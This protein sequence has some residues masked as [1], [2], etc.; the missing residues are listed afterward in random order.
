MNPATGLAGRRR[1]GQ[2][3]GQL[4]RLSRLSPYL[5]LLILPGI[6]ADSAFLRLVAGSAAAAPVTPLE[7]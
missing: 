6:D 5:L 4:R 3:L 2:L 1:T 7:P